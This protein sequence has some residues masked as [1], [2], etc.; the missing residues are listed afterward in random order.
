MVKKSLIINIPRE[1]IE[2]KILLIRGKKVILDRDLAELYEV[3]VKHLKRQVRRN[4]ERFP[5]DF[6][7]VL[8]N[9]ECGFLRCQNGSLKRGEHSK[10]LPY[11]F[12]EHFGK[13][14]SPPE[15]PKRKLAFAITGKNM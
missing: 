1:R 10:Y 15:T 5:E 4:I 2:S 3:E 14:L 12:T 8:T 6:M 9:K 7:F 11:A 13:L